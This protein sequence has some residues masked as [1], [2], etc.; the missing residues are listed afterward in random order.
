MDMVA[1]VP[2]VEELIV[3][4]LPAVPN[5]L[6]LLTVV[7]VDGTNNRLRALVASEKLIVLI[8]PEAEMLSEPVEP[9]TV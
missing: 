8:A 7:V 3:M 1:V 5:T 2:G 4:S 9:A 6:K